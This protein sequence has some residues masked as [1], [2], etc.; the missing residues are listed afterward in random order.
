MSS[1]SP[2]PQQQVRFTQAR[3]PYKLAFREFCSHIEDR[4]K[5]EKN[6]IWGVLVE[7]PAFAIVRGRSR[8]QVSADPGGIQKAR[9][10]KSWATFKRHRSHIKVRGA[11]LVRDSGFQGR[12]RPVYVSG[13][14]AA[15]RGRCSLGKISVIGKNWKKFGLGRSS[16][17]RRVSLD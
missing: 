9:F 4:Q 3:R 8:P 12:K 17:G 16:A 10:G 7:T 5:Q 2:P 15:C 6:R 13:I 14:R 1:R 11:R